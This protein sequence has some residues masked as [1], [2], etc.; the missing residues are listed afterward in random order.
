MARF[1]VSQEVRASATAV[2]AALVDWPRHGDWAPL[3]SVRVTTPR[4]DG[5]GAQ[6]VG[7][8]GIGPLAFDDPMTVR[9]WEP[10]AGDTPGDAPGRCEVVKGGRVVLGEA[11]FSVVPLPGGRC[12]VDWGE[13]VTVTPHRLT[14]FAGPLLSLAGRV[15]FG[16]TLRAMAREVQEQ[17]GRR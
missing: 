3:T 2:W 14:R 9:L 5:V 15:G 13:D 16:A 1:T 11:W 12:R 17:T 4:P 7:R 6:F 10:P 8:T